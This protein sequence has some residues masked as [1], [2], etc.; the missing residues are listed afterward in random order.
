[1]RAWHEGWWEIGPDDRRSAGAVLGV[2]PGT[3]SMHQN[4][5]V[6]LGVI[7][8]CY[9]FDGPRRK[10]VM[11]DLEFPSNMYLFEGFR[12]YGADV[13]YVPS[14]DTDADEPGSASRRD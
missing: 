10:I 8:S 5:T 7:A 11:T 6:A 14:D 4:V 9:T 13:V 12:R 3:I 2:Q 1:M